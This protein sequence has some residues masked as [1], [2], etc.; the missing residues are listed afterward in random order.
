MPKKQKY[1]KMV[2]SPVGASDE[3]VKAPS[4]GEIARNERLRKEDGGGEGGGTVFTSSNTGIFTP[5]FGGGSGRKKKKHNKLG[6][7][8]RFM[9]DGIQI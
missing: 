3:G 5:T 2:N 9:N 1:E 7:V 4:A 6:S 8:G